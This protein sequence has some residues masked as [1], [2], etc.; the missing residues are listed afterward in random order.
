MCYNISVDTSDFFYIEVQ[1]GSQTSTHTFKD[2]HI[3]INLSVSWLYGDSNMVLLMNVTMLLYS[4]QLYGLE[5][6]VGTEV[7]RR[8]CINEIALLT[9]E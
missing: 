9:V 7:V 1:S 4:M 8:L 3:T 5:A 6:E 2:Y